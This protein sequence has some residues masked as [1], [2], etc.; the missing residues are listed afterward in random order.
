MKEKLVA[1][2]IFSIAFAFVEATVVFYLREIFNYSDTYIQTNY[3]TLLNLGII[4]FIIPNVPVLYDAQINIAE[5]Q[6]EIATIIMLLSIAFLSASLW[7]QRIGAF[8]I[9]FGVW[10]IFYYIFLKYLTNWPKTLFDI[11]V[12]FL[13]PVTWVGPVITPI[14]IS[15]LLIIL[16]LKLYKSPSINH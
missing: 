9:A 12:Y 11:D 3:K 1:L 10:D 6:R 7:K 13:I 16:G 2:V 8:L 15:I 4:A 14:V 5:L